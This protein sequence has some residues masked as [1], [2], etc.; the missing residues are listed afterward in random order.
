MMGVIAEAF[1]GLV[2]LRPELVTKLVTM[3]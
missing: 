1:H 3:R 2:T